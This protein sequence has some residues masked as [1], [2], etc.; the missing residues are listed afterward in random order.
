VPSRNHLAPRCGGDFYAKKERLDLGFLTV[1]TTGKTPAIISPKARRE[2][3]PDRSTLQR[4]ALADWI[5]DPVHG[6]GALL[7]RVMVNRICSITS[8]RGSCA[9]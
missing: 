6:A 3:P 5:T 9:P 8:A 4:R 2:G 1:L 7:A